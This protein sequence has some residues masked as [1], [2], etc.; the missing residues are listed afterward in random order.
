MPPW[1]RTRAGSLRRSRRSLEALH[2]ARPEEGPKAEECLPG[3]DEDEGARRREQACSNDKTCIK[4][5]CSEEKARSTPRFRS[6]D[7]RLLRQAAGASTCHPRG[8]AQAGRRG[9]ARR[10]LVAQVGHAILYD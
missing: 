5:G 2:E 3:D 9:S 10:G 1:R 8:A 4:E 7:R 6:A